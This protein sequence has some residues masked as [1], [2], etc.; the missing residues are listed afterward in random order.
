MEQ[1]GNFPIK[2][3]KIISRGL[4][5]KAVV[6]AVMGS[7]YVGLSLSHIPRTK[8]ML[9][10]MERDQGNLAAVAKAHEMLSNGRAYRT[11]FWG[12]VRGINNYLEQ[13]AQ[14]NADLELYLEKK[15][16]AG[17]GLF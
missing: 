4:I 1:I 3:N 17:L 6:A 13:V 12:Q 8:S 14:E 9:E 15:G 10:S 7:L 16:E 11:I 5:E 2:R